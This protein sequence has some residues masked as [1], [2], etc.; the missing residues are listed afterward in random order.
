LESPWVNG[1]GA[2]RVS[3]YYVVALIAASESAHCEY[4]RRR[5]MGSTS[6]RG[7]CCCSQPRPGRRGSPRIAGSC[8][9]T[10]LGHSR[11]LRIV[12][13]GVSGC[14]GQLSAVRAMQ[15]RRKAAV[16][17]RSQAMVS[18]RA[19]VAM[20]KDAAIGLA[21]GATQ[22]CVGVRAD[23]QADGLG[24]DAILKRAAA[25]TA[26]NGRR[27]VVA[28]SDTLVLSWLRCETGNQR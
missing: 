7:W 18:G 23:G 17:R 20:E 21:V 6:R 15:K 12:F 11:D 24:A 13:A 26:S 28:A 3:S 19:Q 8:P 4:L 9:A 5:H 2:L 22:S 1:A 10:W 14:R 25:F 16:R 27:H